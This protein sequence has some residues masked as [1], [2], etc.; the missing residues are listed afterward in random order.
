MAGHSTE[1]LEGR[2]HSEPVGCSWGPEDQDRGGNEGERLAASLGPRVQPQRVCV[3]PLWLLS[4]VTRGTTQ[5]FC[6]V[7]LSQKALA[8]TG[9]TLI[10]TSWSDSG[11]L[12]QTEVTRST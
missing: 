8:A 6:A 12:G 1:C 10:T 4:T 2:E 9:D 7:V 11:L 3:P 5:E